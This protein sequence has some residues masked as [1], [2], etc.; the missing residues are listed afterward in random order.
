MHAVLITVRLDPS[1]Q[2][3]VQQALHERIVPLV[4]SEPDEPMQIEHVEVYEVVAE[5]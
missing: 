5:A 4:K 1:R 2:D 3:D